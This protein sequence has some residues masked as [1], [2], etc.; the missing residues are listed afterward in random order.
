MTGSLSHPGPT[1]VRSLPWPMTRA[2]RAITTSRRGPPRPTSAARSLSRWPGARSRSR[3]HRDLQ[4]RPTSTSARACC[5]APFPRRPAGPCSTS[6]A[7]G[8][9]S[10]SPWPLLR[11]EATRVG[12]RRQR[13]RPRP[14]ASQRRTLAQARPRAESWRV[15][16]DDVP[17]D[18]AFDAIWSNP[19]VRDRQGAPSTP[20][21]PR[22]SPASPRAP[23]PTSSSSATWAPTRSPAGSRSSATTRAHR[24]GAVEK[25]ASAKGFRVF[26]V[27][28]G[29][30]RAVASRAD[31]AAARRS[32]R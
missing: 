11:P 6:A 4:S 32:R 13:A 1:R 12:R 31:P 28:R 5:S 24:S 29:A 25:I 9:R 19:P 14:A 2:P 22:G 26:R 18:L 20:S 8:A 27:T 3:R 7:A 16:P 21:W 30:A 15:T 17:A 23:R 10:R